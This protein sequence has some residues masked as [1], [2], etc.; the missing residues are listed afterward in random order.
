[1]CKKGFPKA[2]DRT[3][4]LENLHLFSK[5]FCSIIVKLCDF[6]GTEYLLQLKLHSI[7]NEF[8]VIYSA[9]SLRPASAY[10]IET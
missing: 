1:M 4:S 8:G 10:V 3:S 2:R 5:P 7:N 6:V 9:Y